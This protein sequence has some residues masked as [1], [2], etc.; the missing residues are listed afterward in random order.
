MQIENT[1]AN[2]ENIFFSLTTQMLEI[3]GLRWVW[4]P[5]G[6]NTNLTGAGSFTFAVDG[7]N[8][9]QESRGERWCGVV[10]ME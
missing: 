7:Q 8:I 1:P 2:E 4:A 9:S 6:P 3:R 5:A 10:E